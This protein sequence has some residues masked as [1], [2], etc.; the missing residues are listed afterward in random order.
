MRS[1][2]QYCF[3]EGLQSLVENQLKR[4]N[5]GLSEK[6]LAAINLEEVSIKDL[7]KKLAENLP[8]LPEKLFELPDN[9][10]KNQT[11]ESEVV[12]TETY[13]ENV[14]QTRNENYTEEYK[15]GIAI[16]GWAVATV[17]EAN[18]LLEIGENQEAKQLLAEEV[19]KFQQVAQTWGNKLINSNYKSELATTYRYAT[20]PFQEYITPERVARITQISPGDTNL[21]AD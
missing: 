21:K 13:Y 9:V 15:S 1:R 2:F 18:L 20:E 17:T 16:Q 12:G 19:Q 11:Q 14:T 6:E 10:Q 7:Q 3:E 8:T 5:V 4:L